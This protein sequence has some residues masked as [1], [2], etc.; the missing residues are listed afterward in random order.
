MFENYNI[1]NYLILMA[2]WVIIIAA[3]GFT[4]MYAWL[5]ITNIK[6]IVRRRKY[7]KQRCVNDMMMKDHYNG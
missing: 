2:V 6:S 5:V 1:I 4:V 7:E 3:G